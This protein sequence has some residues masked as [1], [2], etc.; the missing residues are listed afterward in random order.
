MCARVAARS[1]DAQSN[2]EPGEGRAWALIGMPREGGHRADWLP[3][4]GWAG[5]ELLWS[6]LSL[7]PCPVA[8]VGQDADGVEDEDGDGESPRIRMRAA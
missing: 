8:V 2:R 7:A 6:H 1:N 5:L 4:L 3:E